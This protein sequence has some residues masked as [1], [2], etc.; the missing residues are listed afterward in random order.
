MNVTW[1]EPWSYN[2]N[3]PQIPYVLYFAEKSYFAGAYL[4]AI[5]YG[6]QTYAPI[7]LHSPRL[8]PSSF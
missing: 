6:T 1:D 4:G 3:A 7:H 5:F 8:F 2:P